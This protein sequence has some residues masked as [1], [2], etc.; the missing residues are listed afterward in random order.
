MQQATR[1][2]ERTKRAMRVAGLTVSLAFATC[3]C[4]G[5]PVGAMTATGDAV[6]SSSSAHGD[7]SRSGDVGQSDGG[8]V[9]AVYS[10]GVTEVTLD[11]GGPRR[12]RLYV[13]ET[14]GT[15]QPRAVVVVLHGGGG[16]GLATSD[17]GQ[18]PLAV[19]RD[20]ADRE[21]FVVAYPEGSVAKDGKYGWTDCRADNLQA[22]QADDVGFLRAVIAR[23]RSDFALP[24]S[25]VF[26]SGTSNGAQMTLAFAAIASDDIAALAISSGNLPE[27]PLP[28]AC[29]Q[30][31]SRPL[32]ALFTHGTAD[33]AMPYGGGC[34]ANLG[35][36]CARGRVLGAEATRDAWL[37]LNGLQAVASSTQTVQKD[38]GD[39]GTADRF[40]YSGAAPV[41]WWRLNG[42]GHPP[43]SQSVAVATTPLT[44]A[45]NRDIEFA[46]V[47]WAFFATRL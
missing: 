23:L 39:A 27:K 37:A 16:Q 4:A 43:P 5:A 2:Q 31:P 13:P 1:E 7:S 29:T 8:G 24:A 21:G 3:G 12:F 18:H 46:E 20:V 6:D 42:A 41:V 9:R 10:A 36:G 17:P 26:M 25:R 33:T 15:T 19:F 35:G 38:A 45:Q 32:P 47:A 34:V 44:G 22:S 40:D 30:G 28:G 11:V 14:L